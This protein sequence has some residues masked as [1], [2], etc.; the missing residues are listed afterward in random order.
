MAGRRNGND[1][2]R[3]GMGVWATD[4]P[5]SYSLSGILQMKLQ[6]VPY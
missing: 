6:G 1:R 4:Y 2:P 5:F 3:G